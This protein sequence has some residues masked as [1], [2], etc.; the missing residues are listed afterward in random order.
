MWTS[1]IELQNY[2]QVAEISPKPE[3]QVFSNRTIIT[4]LMYIFLNTFTALNYT[5]WFVLKEPC[6][7]ENQLELVTTFL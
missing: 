5:V 1:R 7:M 2:A 4:F 6:R 3:Q